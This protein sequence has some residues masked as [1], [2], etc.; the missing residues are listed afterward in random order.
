MVMGDGVA[1]VRAEIEITIASLAAGR[2]VGEIG[3]G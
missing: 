1:W 3:V 2:G